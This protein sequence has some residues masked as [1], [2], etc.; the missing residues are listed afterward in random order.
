MTPVTYQVVNRL[1][2]AEQE[3]FFDTHTKFKIVGD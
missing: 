2:K 1:K 3:D